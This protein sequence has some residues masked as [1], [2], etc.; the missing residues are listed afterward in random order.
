MKEVVNK[1]LKANKTI[2]TME[3]CTG[4]SLASAITN[5]DLSSD[6]MHFSA[7]T[8]SNEFKVKFGVSQEIIDKYTVYSKEV[9]REMARSITEFT[10]SNYGVGTTGRLNCKDIRN[11]FDD[12]NDIVNICIYD[13]D[14]DIYFDEEIKVTLNSRQENKNLIVERIANVLN[15]I[16]R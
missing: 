8:Y 4:G 5:I 11:D 10:K 14:N 6:V 1:L 12:R 15:E 3:S 9:A 16:I 13:R 7:V 2:S